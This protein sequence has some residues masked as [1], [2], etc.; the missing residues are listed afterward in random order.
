MNVEDFVRTTLE[1]I[2]KAVNFSFKNGDNERRFRISK[3]G[4]EFDLAVSVSQSDKTENENSSGG[5]IKV[6]QAQIGSKETNLRNNETVSRIKFTV[7]TVHKSGSD[8]AI[9]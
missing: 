8:V 7:D 5:N 4:V 6:L 3:S 1:S 2:S 9:L